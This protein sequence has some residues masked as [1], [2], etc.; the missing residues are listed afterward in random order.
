MGVTAAAAV[1]PKQRQEQL[2]AGRIAAERPPSSVW[3]EK[4][5]VV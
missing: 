2:M 5:F 4:V 1:V 3:A